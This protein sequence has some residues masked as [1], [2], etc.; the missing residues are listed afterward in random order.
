MR[1]LLPCLVLTLFGSCSNPTQPSFSPETEEKSIRLLLKDQEDAWN[2]SDVEAFMKGYWKSDSLQFI[3][4][5]VT[6]GW[7]STL[8]RYKRNYPTPEMM[9]QLQF[10]LYEFKFLSPTACLVTGRYNLKRT[11]DSP[12]GM[13]TLLFRKK[14]DQW[15]IVYDHTS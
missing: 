8:V 11:Q 7:D 12:T 13:F 10:D 15:V 6:R 3:G 5:K 2:R 4:S 9:G 1:F 14:N